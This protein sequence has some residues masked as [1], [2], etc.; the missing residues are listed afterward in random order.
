MG[1]LGRFV[2]QHLHNPVGLA[3]RLVRSGDP[4]ARGA[5]LQAALGVALAPLDILLARRE[6]RLYALAQPPVR[7][8]LFVCGPPR[9]G[10][11]LVTQV[12]LAHLPVEYLSNV[13]ALFPRAPLI[14]ERLL[15]PRLRPWRP[16]FH[17]YYGRVA[18]LRGPND[19]L[20]LWDRWLGHDRTRVRDALTAE[21]SDAMRRFFGAMERLAGRPF[22]GK[23]NNLNLQAGAVGKAMPTARFLCLT[24]D[25]L[26]LAQ[27][28]LRARREIHGAD[29]MTYGLPAPEPPGADPIESVCR[30]VVY[31]QRGALAQQALLG[32][33]RFRFLAYEEFCAD[34]A[35]TVLLAAG[36]LGIAEHDVCPVAPATRF[37]PSNRARLSEGEFAR[38]RATLERMQAE[39]GTPAR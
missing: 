25:P 16:A 8:Q 5:M 26:F 33:E 30:Q 3:A 37:S 12:L 28:L 29:D 19:S 27:A 17:S 14:A 21:E 35:A 22:V 1:F 11:S 32:P 34:P 23:N 38:L 15:R 18:A 2:P 6:R 13:T 20:Q 10:T 39:T 36:N 31:H 9:S 24:R 4:D 7:P